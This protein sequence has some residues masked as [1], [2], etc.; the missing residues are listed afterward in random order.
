[1]KTIMASIIMTLSLTALANTV[2]GTNLFP[3]YGAV[4][5]NKVCFTENSVKVSIPARTVKTCV[6]YNQGFTGS[7]CAEYKSVTKPAVNLEAPLSFETK[8]CV[9]TKPVFDNSFIRKDVCV[10]TGTI[11]YNQPRTYSVAKTVQTDVFHKDIVFV[12]HTIPACQ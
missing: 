9:E 4:A 8:G 12:K 10:K 3:G 7:T 5:S 11:R 2:V 1:M 6:K